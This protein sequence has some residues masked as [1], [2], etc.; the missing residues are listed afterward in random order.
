MCGD[1]HA[2]IWVTHVLI[3][4]GLQQHAEKEVKYG[5]SLSYI[6]MCYSNTRRQLCTY[7]LIWW[8][9]K[10][11]TAKIKAT[12]LLSAGNTLVRPTDFPGV[13]RLRVWGCTWSLSLSFSPLC[14]QHCAH[15]C[16]EL[17]PLCATALL[18]S[19]PADLHLHLLCQLY[20]SGSQ[21]EKHHL[22]P[23]QTLLLPSA[24]QDNTHSLGVWRP[25]LFKGQNRRWC[26]RANMF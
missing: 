19:C 9:I 17:P 15:S 1:C 14:C 11:D 10:L 24:S 6:Y 4:Y 23:F 22:H 8:D 26:C 12:E 21:S 20:G 3:T 25:R 7:I 16:S 2:R 13:L 18:S 5:Y